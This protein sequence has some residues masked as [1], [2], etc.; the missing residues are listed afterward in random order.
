MTDQVTEY[1]EDEE[2]F[3]ERRVAFTRHSAWF[4][5][6]T[7]NGCTAR[8]V[9]CGAVGSHIAL[10]LAKMGWG[11]FELW[12]FDRVATHNLPNQAYDVEHIGMPK[13]EALASVLRRFNPDIKV[14]AHNDRF[15]KDV[16]FE[17]FGPLILA[18]DSFKSRLLVAEFA[19]HNPYV[20]HIFETRLG[21]DFGA[22][23]I[24]NN[25]VEEE[26]TNFVSSLGDDTKVSEL[27]C[28]E[29]I[30]TTLVCNIS[31]YVAHQV[32]ALQR[33]IAGGFD[34]NPLAKRT[35]FQLDNAGLCVTN[36]MTKKKK[37][38]KTDE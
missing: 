25:M 26:I 12:D 29:K 24:I 32:C 11:E 8:I 17:T 30:C 37:E 3:K 4:S 5:P 38:K 1:I 28:N 36:I 16:K 2:D 14:I 6:V 20:T 9:G 35:M 27:P 22:T 13:V 31:S 19:L 33:S 34:Y 7:A 15:T 10:F 21:F 23:A 18:T